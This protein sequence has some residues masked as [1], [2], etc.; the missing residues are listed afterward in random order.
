MRRGQSIV[1]CCGRRRHRHGWRGRVPVDVKSELSLEDVIF[2]PVKMSAGLELKE[3]IEIYDYEVEAFKLVYLDGLTTDEA[4]TRMG[5]SKATFWRILESCRVK[6]AQAL[7]E[8]KPIKLVSTS[9][10]DIKEDHGKAY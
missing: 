2:I 4:S 9:R 8:S 7:V 5:V 3:Y 6:L 1:H 10:A